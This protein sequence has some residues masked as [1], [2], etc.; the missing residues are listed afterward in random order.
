MILASWIFST[1]TMTLF[2]YFDLKYRLVPKI[3]IQL[4]FYVSFIIYMIVDYFLF[5]SIT[6]Q[7]ITVGAVCFILTFLLFTAGVVSKIIGPADVRIISAF[8]F[9]T[10]VYTFSPLGKGTIPPIDFFLNFVLMMIPTFLLFRLHDPKKVTPALVAVSAAILL[11]LTIGNLPTT[12]Y[13]LFKFFFRQHSISQFFNT[14]L[15]ASSVTESL[16][17][18]TLTDFLNS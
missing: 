16:H 15:S 18:N 6:I 5:R 7:E 13:Y 2:T 4:F 11:T 1:V 14:F 3:Y 10:P 9:L 17:F 12:I 8:V